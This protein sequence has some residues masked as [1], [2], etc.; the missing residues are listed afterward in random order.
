MTRGVVCAAVFASFIAVSAAAQSV[1]VFVNK[2]APASAPAGA[3]IT[4]VV[5]VG[6]NGPNAASSVTLSDA[7]PAG[8]TF[9]SYSQTGPAFLCSTPASGTNGTISC[10]IAT[11]AS[12]ASTEFDIAVHLDSGLA[13]GTVLNN[14]AAATTSSS[15]TNANN[16][17]AMAST[18][19]TAESDM[20]V[21]KSAPATAATGSN[22]TF[23]VTAGNAGPNDAPNAHF[24]DV[25][26]S[27][28]G[29][30]SINQTAGPTFN[31]TTPAAGASGTVTCTIATLTAGTSA[32]FDI[33]VTVDPKAAGTTLINTV[34]AASDNPDGNG[35]NNTS[36]TGTSV[37]GGN[38]ADLRIL[39]TGPVSQPADT[40]VTYTI[41]LTNDGPSDATTV[42]LI[43]N[44]PNSIPPSSPLTFVSFNQNSGPTFAC[45]AGATTTCSIQTFPAGSTATFTL[46]AHIPP[47][48]PSGHTYTNV[49][50]MTSDNDPNPDNDTSSSTVTISSA[51]IGVTKSGPATAVA[52][53]PTYNYVVTLSNGGP[54]EATDVSFSDTLPTGLT[55]VGVVQNT[56]P[57]A[58]CNGGQTVACTIGL[59]PSNQSAQFTITVQPQ[60][61]IPNG[62]VL[63]NTAT[64]STSSAD[65]N[66]NNNSASVNTTVNANADLS[67]VKTA[68]LTVLAGANITYG[69]TVTNNG[70]SSASGVTW[71]DLL[72]PSLTF[73]SFQQTSGPVFTCTTGQ[74]ISCSVGTLAPAATAVFSIIAHVSP[75]T[76]NGST[77][78]NTANVLS[79]TP[80]GTPL[81]NGSTTNTTVSTSADLSAM[82]S[83]PPAATAGS[84]F[85][86]TIG[87]ANAGPSDATNVTLSDVLPA[88]TTFVSETQRS[89]PTFTCTTGATI[90]CTIAALIVGASATFDVTVNV[91]V[92][93]PGGTVFSN[94]ANAASSTPDP[95]PNNNTATLSTTIGVNADLAV[96]KTG[97]GVTPSNTTVTYTVLAINN[98][99]SNA[100]NVS[101]TETVPNGMTF[102][103]VNQTS[104]PAF[105]CSGT[106]PIVCTIATLTSGAI[107]S[108][109][110]T[111]NVPVSAAPGAVATDTATITSATPDPSPANN[112]AT[113]ITTIGQSIPAL[114]PLAMA[115]LAVMMAMIGWVVARR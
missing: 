69:V 8:V 108:F 103:S 79:S 23:T 99:P 58:T 54:D 113:A 75:A 110:F 29:F 40:D 47:G 78:T 109:Q 55:F 91:P 4:Y 84:D 73:V 65:T 27:N 7:L 22:I 36:E 96:R 90:N 12:G 94:T 39:K 20:F 97:P 16:D 50:K 5:T 53:G 43:D 13:A 2:T 98:G 42:S 72:P 57:A 70:P 106:G 32:Q 6:N 37:P 101:L 89:G 33:V 95:N 11:L 9:V 111:F 30:V 15:D 19:I 83:A 71:N 115:M 56:G 41:S 3:T 66:P 17:S 82:K 93:T 80:D 25:L 74:S 92:A 46:V 1:D 35:E 59:L 52:G 14:T 34:T 26:P 76:P 85:T 102:A 87:V 31:C 107:A 21:F 44:L 62:T 51:D 18:T 68:P 104:G 105:T 24:V 67:L 86:Y 112:T 38:L 10:S 81:N 48:T 63:M 60:P 77:I 114:S 28:V 64:A 88:G 49:V 61:T 100:T 45:S